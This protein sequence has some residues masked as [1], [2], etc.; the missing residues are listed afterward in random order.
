[1]SKNSNQKDQPKLGSLFHS[2]DQQPAA[3][4]REKTLG[5]AQKTKFPPTIPTT[6]RPKAVPKEDTTTTNAKK[7]DPQS[8]GLKYQQLLPQRQQQIVSGIFASGP[9]GSSIGR[10]SAF[11]SNPFGQPSR[12]TPNSTGYIKR[13]VIEDDH[14][15]STQE[16]SIKFIDNST[17][18][19]TNMHITKEQ[20]FEEQEL[21]LLQVQSLPKPL[22][23]LAGQSGQCATMRIRQSGKKELVF[24]GKGKEEEIVFDLASLCIGEANG[25]SF[26]QHL[27]ALEDAEVGK[28]S[29]LGEVLQKFVRRVE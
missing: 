17:A 28:L 29:A 13:T 9:V 26:P 7:E 8:K 11:S 16:H 4:P 15:P 14:A 19:N 18:P 3:K 24:I 23:E 5:A 20:P 2:T 25:S 1:M 21:F 22:G 10:K 6:R 27:C 12:S